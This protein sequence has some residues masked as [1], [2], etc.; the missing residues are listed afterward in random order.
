MRR[1]ASTA[2]SAAAFAALTV[3]GCAGGN[4]PAGGSGSS[5]AAA[6]SSAPAAK[7][8]APLTSA[9]LAERLLDEAD[10]GQ[11]YTRKPETSGS[12]NDVTVIGCPALENLGGDA[13]AGGSLDFPNNAKTTFAYTR[14]TDSE[15]AEELYSDT[16]DKLGP[17][18]K[19]VFE[20]MTG[21]PLYRVVVG[22]TPI[23]V[24][25]QQLPAPALGDEAWS[26]LLTFTAGG[27]D[28]VM[29]QTAVRAGSVLVVVSGSPA[30]VDTH[31]TRAVDKARG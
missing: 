18:T 14:G 1:R 28:T 17:G 6:V 16:L 12:R 22:D 3:S 21:C 10:L 19:T 29:K 26:Q 31:L 4:A 24:A 20:A 23:A 7:P 13:A 25:T 8:A 27:R 30:L 5:P 11:G 15:V 2:L 9:A